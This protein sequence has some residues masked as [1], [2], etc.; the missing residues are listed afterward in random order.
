M[1][2]GERLFPGKRFDPPAVPAFRGSNARMSSDPPVKNSLPVSDPPPVILAE[3]LPSAGSAVVDLA[4][5]FRLQGI[6]D[7]IRAMKGLLRLKPFDTTTEQGRSRERYRRAMLTTFSSVLARV[8]TVS[9]ALIAVRLTVRYLGGERY[10]LWMT[11]TSVVAMMA[12]ADLGIGNGLLNCIS[13]AHGREDRESLHRYVSSAFFIL[14]GIAVLLLGLFALVYPFVPWPRVFNVSSAT[15]VREA[16]PAV[17]VFL[18]CCALNMPLDVVQRVKTGHQE[19]FETNLWN[20]AGSLTGFT[21]LLVAMH[22]KAG[23]PWLVLAV[24]GGPLLG[25]LGNWSHE[26]GWK[27]PWLLPRRTYWDPAAAR[28]IM[29]TGAMFLVIQLCGIFVVTVDNIVIAQILGPGAVTQYAVPMRMFLMLSSAACLFVSP[30]WPAYGEALARGDVKWVKRT[31]IRS[32]VLSFA[33]FGP[34]ALG[35]AVFGKTIVHVWVG[36]QIQPSYLL[37]AGAAVWIMVN[38]C[39]NAL[40]TFLNGANLLK[41]QVLIYAATAIV[42]L[43]AKVFC[44]KAFGLAG[45]VWVTALTTVLGT[46]AVAVYAYRVLHKLESSS[47]ARRE[48]EYATVRP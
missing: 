8:V 38:V 30:L 44:A 33:T 46:V 9:T 2:G 15:A 28:K 6:L 25:I 23:L 16:G 17:V 32:V 5:P 42:N 40:G 26:F 31:V 39:G 24:S 36:P 45:V 27:R 1:G 47:K 48:A 14:G 22:L 34:V 37:L 10:G 41:F 18:C 7:R 19:G 21:L 43:P 29:G 11:I 35:L 12:F 4:E 13:E 20:A 3:A